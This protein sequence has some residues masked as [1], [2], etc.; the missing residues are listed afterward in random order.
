MHFLRL[1]G[2]GMGWYSQPSTRATPTQQWLSSCQITI[3]LTITQTW[4]HQQSP[5]SIWQQMINS[6]KST[7]SLAPSFQAWSR[8]LWNIRLLVPSSSSML[9]GTTWNYM[10]ATDSSQ[11]SRA[12]KCK[13]VLQFQNLWGRVLTFP[14]KSGTSSLTYTSFTPFHPQELANTMHTPLSWK[15]KE[16]IRL[17]DVIWQ[18][19]KLEWLVT[20]NSLLRMIER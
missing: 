9:S 6:D 14:P 13:P 16:C 5:S 7:F 20:L 4:S 8:M 11:T 18:F 10:S 3:Y 12:L 19:K 1:W 15:K 17:W 2:R